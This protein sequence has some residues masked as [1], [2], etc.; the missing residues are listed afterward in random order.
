MSTK[1]RGLD[2][3]GNHHHR[4]ELTVL[5]DGAPEL[6]QALRVAQTQAGKPRDE[7]M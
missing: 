3:L 6:G 5:T 7:L 2:R 1:P 4:H